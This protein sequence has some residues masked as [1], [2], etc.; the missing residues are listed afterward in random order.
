MLTKTNYWKIN[1]TLT[2]SELQLLRDTWMKQFKKWGKKISIGI[3]KSEKKKR[4][5]ECFCVQT[6]LI[7][8]AIMQ[9]QIN[10]SQRV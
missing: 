5:E 2:L 10:A 8:Y 1:S 9:W 3:C 4:K 6:L 7:V